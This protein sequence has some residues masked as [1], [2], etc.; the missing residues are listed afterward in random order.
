MGE[1]DS[2][3]IRG[4]QPVRK[5]RVDIG[6]LGLLHKA[7]G[8]DAVVPE[9]FGL[10]VPKVEL[11]FFFEEGGGG[12]GEELSCGAWVLGLRLRW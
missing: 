2:L 8:D 9:S 3:I 5:L 1:Y 7:G 6:G 12:L 11:C 10:N 4:S